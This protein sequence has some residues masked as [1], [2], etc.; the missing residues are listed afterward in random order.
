MPWWIPAL[1]VAWLAIAIVTTIL[2]RPVY[3]PG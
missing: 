2:K 3:G 1:V